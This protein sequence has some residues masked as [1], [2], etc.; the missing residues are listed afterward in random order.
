MTAN[1][2]RL[3]LW[4]INP[5]F[6]VFVKVVADENLRWH[7]LASVVNCGTIS[8]CD[9]SLS[10][11]CNPWLDEIGRKKQ[12]AKVCLQLSWNYLEHCSFKWNLTKKGFHSLKRNFNRDSYLKL[13]LNLVC[14][15]WCLAFRNHPVPE[16]LAFLAAPAQ[17]FKFL[18]QSIFNVN[19]SH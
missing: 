5:K 7:A 4:T 15:L 18:R 12:F 13:L 17:N 14:M 10:L 2:F 3:V 11:N 6:A 16:I 9:L 19:L 1:C 8:H